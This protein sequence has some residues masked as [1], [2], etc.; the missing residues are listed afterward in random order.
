MNGG[1][2]T[3]ECTRCGASTD[4]CRVVLFWGSERRAERF[5]CEQCAEILFRGF[6]EE[7]DPAARKPSPQQA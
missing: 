5:V 7:S 4:D 6:L 1:Q 3:T 2:Q